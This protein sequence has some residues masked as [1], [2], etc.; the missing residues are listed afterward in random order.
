MIA[1]R[2]KDERDTYYIDFA[3][4]NAFKYGRLVIMLSKMDGLSYFLLA[5]TSREP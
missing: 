4:H 2:E 3:Y 5:S 1:N